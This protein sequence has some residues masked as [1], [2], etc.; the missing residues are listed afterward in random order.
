MDLSAFR[1]STQVAT[2]DKPSEHLDLP[3]R[4]DKRTELSISHDT[5]VDDA[6]HQSKTKDA[7][8]SESKSAVATESAKRQQPNEMG[9]YDAMS[10]QQQQDDPGLDEVTTNWQQQ[11]LASKAAL[12][13]LEP[14]D[15]FESEWPERK[16]RQSH[17]DHGAL[18]REAVDQQIDQ[19]FE[20]RRPSRKP[21]RLP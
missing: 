6:M 3:E 17:H 5:T 11:V 8:G 2:I 20:K 4:A 14:N 18:T 16:P 10:R 7:S 9:E 21:P 12:S 19:S 1:R 13:Q 15:F